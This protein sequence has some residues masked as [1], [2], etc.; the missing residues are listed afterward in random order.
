MMT[1][2]AR[3][4]ARRDCGWKRLNKWPERCPAAGHQQ[5]IQQK[6]NT[7]TEQYETGI[8]FSM[9]AIIG[10]KG[11]SADGFDCRLREFHVRGFGGGCEFACLFRNFR[12]F[13]HLPWRSPIFSRLSRPWAG[14][15]S[16]RPIFKKG[17]AL[18]KTIGSKPRTPSQRLASPEKNGEPP[19][20]VSV[21]F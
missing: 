9:S 4:Y 20:A 2:R 14:S 12:H 3:M 6:F 8:G 7:D 21:A 13:Q 10:L 17:D 11:V 16:F 5:N 19:S 18:S 15:H 1:V